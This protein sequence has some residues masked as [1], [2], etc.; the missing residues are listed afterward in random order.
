MNRPN[1][2]LDGRTALVTGSSKG[3]GYAIAGGIA[4]AGAR[5]VL[6]SR[7]KSTLDS[8]VGELR[9]D[10]L[11]V[12][13]A[14]FDI[15]DAKAV[16]AAVDEIESRIGPIDILVNNAGVARRG[17]F[18]DMSLDD[19]SYVMDINVTGAFLV[20][21]A[22][23]PGMKRRR[24]GKIINMCSLMS[25]IA[26]RDNTNY[27]A[28]KGAIAMFTKALAVELAADGITA[29]GI[30]PGFIDTPLTQPL[31]NDTDFSEWLT[32]RAPMGRWGKPEELIGTAVFLA[33][34]ASGFITGQIIYV[35]GGLTA[36]I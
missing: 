19:W 2:S 5:V 15:T 18:D 25:S 28:S 11:P 23:V 14:C 9:S 6:N 29:N 27:A 32:T 4:G 21:K 8:A 30:A 24:R 33:S 10:G 34:E 26:R 7:T 35:D 12:E 36:V 3:I 17:K 1:F 31:V 22:I 20:T 16:I 13:G